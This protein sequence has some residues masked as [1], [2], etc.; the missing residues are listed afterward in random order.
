[1]NEE[2]LK[3]AVS[4]YKQG[5]KS[6]AAILLGEIVRQDPSNSLAW[7]GLALSLDEPDKK[8]YCIK[9]V[10]S[11]DPSHQKAR[12]LLEKL[13]S[14]KIFSA[15]IKQ[16][17]AENSYQPPAEK[18]VSKNFAKKLLNESTGIEKKLVLALAGMVLLL[19]LC[20]SIAGVTS[21]TKQVQAENAQATATAKYDLCKKQFENEMARLLSQFFRQENI[22]DVTARINIPEQ[23]SRL[24]EIRTETWSMPEKS[25]NPKTHA[26]LMDYMDKSIS[27]SI[28]FAADDFRWITIYKE[29]LVALVALDDEVIR[30]FN[31][32][33]LVSMF[34]SKGYFYWEGLDNPNWK[35][36]LDV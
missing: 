13:Q 16:Q 31:K 8:I 2:K 5:N 36:E 1:M 4:L 21:W 20:V 28:R 34:R 17:T 3:E 14:E 35:N 25:C 29:S 15:S 18:S 19:V 22:V 6:E 7:Y 32:G 11:L 30:T 27:S 9:K 26:L 24:E 23:I 10:V 12:Q 33:G